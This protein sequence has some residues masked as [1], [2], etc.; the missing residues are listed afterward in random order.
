LLSG[1]REH[2]QPCAAP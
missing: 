1:A 2:S